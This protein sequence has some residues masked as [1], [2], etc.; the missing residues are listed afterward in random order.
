MYG[1]LEE[2]HGLAKRAMLI[3][4]RAT[5]TVA[6]QDKFEVRTT[7]LPVANGC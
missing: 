2:D 6:D 3:Y 7:L 1:K 4:E 5:Q